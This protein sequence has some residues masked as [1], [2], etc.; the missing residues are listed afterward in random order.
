MT[1]CCECVATKEYQG[2]ALKERIPLIL[3]IMK[4]QRFM[5]LYTIQTRKSG[6]RFLHGLS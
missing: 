5:S 3:N 4:R 6:K 2:T 1:D